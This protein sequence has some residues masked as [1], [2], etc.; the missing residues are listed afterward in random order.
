MSRTPTSGSWLNLVEVWFGLI[1]R[2]AIR[3]GVLPSV[4]DLT[5]KIRTFINGWNH[6]K[7]PF[8]WTKTPDEILTK[9]NRN[10]ALNTCGRATATRPGG[11][12]SAHGS[13]SP[14]IRSD[15]TAAPARTS[16]MRILRAVRLHDLL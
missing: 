12:A 3:R 8:I 1:E 11:D 6:R 15:Q 10:Q 9:I 14:R 2:Q 13:R 7:H 4:H 16:T 5:A